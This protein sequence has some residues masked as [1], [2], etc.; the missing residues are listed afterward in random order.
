MERLTPASR[1]CALAAAAL[2]HDFNSE[3]T[4]ILSSVS[5]AILALEPGHPARSPLLDLESSARRCAR[6][7]GDVL[8]F[9]A[10][11][12]VRPARAPLSAVMEM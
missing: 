1:A 7:C 3:L 10:R 12:G 9:S 5:D 4:V 11:H 6:K 2:A 8:A